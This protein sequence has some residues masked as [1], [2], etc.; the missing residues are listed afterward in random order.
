MY[1][2]ANDAKAMAALPKVSFAKLR[3]TDG[4][5]R[6]W[7]LDLQAAGGRMTDEQIVDQFH[8][9]EPRLE[10]LDTKMDQLEKRL[11]DGF[12]VANSRLEGLENRL[13]RKAD[14]WVV[15]A[16]ME[17]IGVLLTIYKFFV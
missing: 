13:A 4:A 3:M 12:A 7:T 14:T 16:G 11:G 6:R 1:Q 8:R 15:T 10:R 5:D 2:L 17:G 9:S